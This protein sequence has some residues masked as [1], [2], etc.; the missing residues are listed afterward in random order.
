MI[1]RLASLASLLTVGFGWPLFCSKRNILMTPVPL[2]GM[3]PALRS[4]WSGA[5]PLLVSRSLY[6]I[7]VAILLSLFTLGGSNNSTF[8]TALALAHV[9]WMLAWM[10]LDEFTMCPQIVC[11]SAALATAASRDH[12]LFE[13]VSVSMYVFG[14]AQ[15][16]NSRFAEWGMRDFFSPLVDRWMPPKCKRAIVERRFW[17]PRVRAAVAYASALAESLLGAGLLLPQPFCGVC[18]A[19]LALMHASVLVAVGPLGSNSAHGI[20][21]WNAMCALALPYLYCVGGRQASLASRIVDA[22]LV[23]ARLDIAATAALATLLPLAAFF[24]HGHPQLSWFM[25][26]ANFPINKCF[27]IGWPSSVAQRRR[28]LPREF[29]CDVTGDSCDDLSS[30]I[31]IV[32]GKI[33]LLQLAQRYNVLPLLSKA[34]GRWWAQSIADALN[35]SVEFRH[36]SRASFDGTR[37]PIH[38]EIV[39]PSLPN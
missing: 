33:D 38:V 39:K 17:S 1:V 36:L 16:F 28:M 21:P 7:E 22:V 31:D 11:Y 20:W 15:K 35:A 34:G 26:S 14:G 8:A 29:R 4:R 6:F 2:C 13:V 5:I 10:A 30:T 24:A 18:A 23:H 3:L 9:A 27:V 25:Y 32:T 19:S 37:P 12:L